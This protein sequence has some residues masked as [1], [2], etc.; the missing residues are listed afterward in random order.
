MFFRIKLSNGRMCPHLLPLYRLPQTARAQN[1][2]PLPRRVRTNKS[3]LS[4]FPFLSLVTWATGAWK[5]RRKNT[6]HS[7]G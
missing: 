2:P 4:S 1:P 3:P 5:G 6:L 7:D